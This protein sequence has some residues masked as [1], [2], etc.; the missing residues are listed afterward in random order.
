[1]PI[2]TG[3]FAAGAA[4]VAGLAWLL[5]GGGAG[6]GGTAPGG[7]GGTTPGGGGGGG[8]GGL[9]P[10]GGK[11]PTGP[12]APPA[13]ARINPST[14]EGGSAWWGDPSKI[15][16][17]FDWN[18]NGIFISTDCTA[19]AIG[20]EFSPVQFTIVGA[21]T[22]EKIDTLQSA[23]VHAPD[24]PLWNFWLYLMYNQGFTQPEDLAARVLAEEAPLCADM[25]DD[26]WPA[27]LSSFYQAL[28]GDAVDFYEGWE[29]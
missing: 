22:R 13:S 26:M 23:R 25:P 5:S 16:A 3:T 14:I 10:G 28:V 6:G 7:G 24:G 2:G 9:K 29:Q 1:M 17:D 27:G 19:I 18:G 20:A 4:I 15:P 21:V 8:G 12:G 11:L